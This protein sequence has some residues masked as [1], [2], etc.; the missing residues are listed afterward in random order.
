MNKYLCNYGLVGGI[1]L[2]IQLIRTRI[3]YRPARLIRFPIFIRGKKF[4]KFGVGFTTG[5][6][7]RLDALGSENKTQIEFG[8]GVQLNDYVH[9]GAI[10]KVVIGNNVL[11]ASRVFI[12]D[13]NHGLYNGDNE[14]SSP[15]ELPAVRPLFANPVIIEDR[16]WIGENACILPGVKIGSGAIIGAGSIVTK[17]VLAETIVAG[18]PARKIKQFDRKTMQWVAVSRK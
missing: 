7:V 3:F 15:D 2:I 14:H 4:I 16:V 6:G 17:D 8:D 13:H 9:I 11:I 1:K 10:E 5:V 18:N 12:S